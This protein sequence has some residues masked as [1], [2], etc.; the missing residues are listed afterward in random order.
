MKTC[1]TCDADISGRHKLT[2]FCS[3]CAIKRNSA[4]SGRAAV[5]ANRQ[6]IYAV[7]RCA[8]RRGLIPP[9]NTRT[10]VD[11]GKPADA[12]DHRDYN[13]PLDVEPVCTGCNVRR[14]PGIP[15]RGAIA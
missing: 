1:E 5:R 11:C 13:K 12:Y 7:L 8:I 2:R 9:V 14:G 10:C 3:D 15:L 6:A 4:S